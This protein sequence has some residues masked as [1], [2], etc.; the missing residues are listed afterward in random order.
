MPTN[1]INNSPGN[2]KQGIVSQKD[3]SVLIR[4]LRYNWWIPLLI[5]PLFYGMGMLYVYRLTNVYRVST[6]FLLK[7]NE[8]YYQ[9]N[10]L[11]DA[12]FY[13]MGGSYVDNVNEQR[14][15]NSYDLANQVVSKLIDRIQVSYFIVGKVRR[16]EEFTGVP[17]IVSIN[18]LNQEFYEKIIDFHVLDFNNYEISYTKD[19][20]KEVKKG[21]FGKELITAD[22]VIT[23]NRNDI[24]TEKKVD[25][26]KDIF[27]QFAIH[28]K[29]YLIQTI[30]GNLIVENPEYTNILKVGLNDI[31]PERAILILDTMNVVYAQNKLKNKF[32]LNDRTVSYIDKQLNEITYSLKSIEDTMQNYKEQKSIIDLE[33]EQEDFLKK[34][35]DYDGQR[36]Q[37]QLQVKALN[38]LENY[39]IEDKDPQFLPPNVMVFEKSGF[40]TQA[41]TELY[42]KQIELNKTYNIAKENNPSIVDLKATIKRTKENLLTYINNTR[43]ATSQQISNLNKE[44][45]TYINEAKLIPGK[46]RDILN[47]QRRTTVSEQL[48]NFLLEKKANTKIARASIVPDIKIVEAPRNI[49]VD[50]P[51]KPAMQKQFL[52]F[53]LLVSILIIVI[54]SVFYSKIKTAEHLKEL[55][56]LPLIGVLPFVKNAESD[57]IIV[58]QTPTALISEAFRNFRTNLQYAN[59]DINAKTYLV[60]SYLPGEGKTFTSSNLAAILAKS[61]KKTV[62]IE[63]DL[64]KPRVYRRFGLLPQTIGITTCITGQNTY[65]E[66]ISETHIANL[67][68]IYS[69]PIPPNPSEFVLSNKMKEIIDRAKID[70]DY[71]I[72]DTPPAGLLS[73]SLYLIQQVDASIFVLNTKSSSKKVINFIEN[74]IEANKLK[75]VLLLLNGVSRAGKKYYY[76]GYGYSYGY[77]Y[78]YG[79]GKGY[80]KTSSKA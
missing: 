61:G 53:G 47:I 3:L 20:N 31:L 58:D 37:L 51:D 78:G 75:N 40:M 48:Y 21:V 8:S 35:G 55:T 34:I 23:I 73:D 26:I 27:Y 64:H 67:Y 25:N 41:V 54:R 9:N 19:N 66:I 24:L 28:S 17:F 45:L 2:K 14:I 68:C 18:T 42:S 13:S 15:I 63:L 59:I 43:K 5:L 39:I 56:D 33:W 30:K 70:F 80:G 4:V 46:Q 16:T 49:G 52:S 77:G 60:T 38:D 1:A 12:N 29:D 6:E 79:Y 22:Y 65:E 76:Q 69:G 10:V 62:L 36:S 71:V 57:G 7:V 72:I 32:E 74:V 44:I 50:S 11:S